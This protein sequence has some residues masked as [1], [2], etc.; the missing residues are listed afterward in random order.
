MTL[1]DRLCRSGAEFRREHRRPAFVLMTLTATD[2]IAARA[3]TQGAGFLKKPFFPADIEAV[4][5]RFYGIEALN[6][7]RT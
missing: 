5:C 6:P 3:R 2:A 4:L 7:E 1:A